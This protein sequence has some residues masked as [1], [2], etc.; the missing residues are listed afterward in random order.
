MI[1]K[2]TELDGV[3]I[4]EPTVFGDARGWFTETF[5]VDKLNQTIGNLDFVQD[6]HSSSQKN[7]LR[8]IHFQNYPY[9]QTKLIRC[10]RGEI[11]DVAVDLRPDSPNYKKWISVVLSAENK[12]QLLIPRG[13]GHGFLSLTDDVEVQYKVDDYYSKQADASIR[14]DDPAIGVDWGISSPILSDKDI[15]APLLADS[16]CNF[17]TRVL[18]TGKDGQLGYDVCKLLTK[19]G[20]PHIGT[21]ISVLDLTN[22]K[23]VQKFTDDYKPTII[24]HCAAYTAVDAAED[25]QDLCF[26]VNEMGTKNLVDAAKK[27]DA[28]LLYISTDYVY[29]GTGTNP[30]KE[31]DTPNPNNIYG[32]SKLAGEITAQTLKKHFILRT[33]WVFGKNG[34]NF[35]KTMLRLASEKPELRIVEDQIGSPTYTVDLA[36]AIVAMVFTDKYGTYNISNDGFCS[37]KDF[38][39]EIFRLSNNKVKVIGVPSKEYATKATR[40]L[41]SRLD[42]SKL[43]EKGFAKLPAWQDAL[44]RYL[45]EI[46]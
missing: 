37:W 23:E 15:T 9:A 35:V 45:E 17:G 32:K 41:N 1:T 34:N 16:N 18:V 28:T 5:R 46:K 39:T 11:L 7:V 8:G 25:N 6:N 44:K 4:I 20:I 3:F 30:N 12:K 33:S 22:A 24:I 21:T 10:T 26:K 43:V 36:V 27:L 13:F 19:K 29:P 31:T 2:Q 40:P 14:F 38:A 42:T